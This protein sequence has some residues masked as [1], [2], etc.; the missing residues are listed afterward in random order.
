MQSKSNAHL[1]F[2]E[3][4]AIHQ[5]R[6]QALRYYFS[7]TN[8]AY[9][10]LVANT[11]AGTASPSLADALLEVD[12]DSCF[13][14]L[15]AIEAALRID[16]ALRCE[17]RDKQPISRRF[18]KLH[19]KYEYSIPLERVLLEEWS[20]HR[21]ALRPTI[22]DLKAALKYR[23]WLAHGRYWTPKFGLNVNRTH[24]YDIYTLAGQLISF[25]LLT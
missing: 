19:K 22:S 14:L 16:Y 20:V 3:V 15:A 2:A 8:P 10:A 21:P 25:G 12:R 18:R 23:N 24:F 9:Q 7:S 1:Q 4:A 13:L 17:R 6:E 11:A 5:L